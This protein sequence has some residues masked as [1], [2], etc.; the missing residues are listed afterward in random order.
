MQPTVNHDFKALEA[1]EA[2]GED[3]KWYTVKIVK[4]NADGT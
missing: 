1:C 4:E 2:L 3:N